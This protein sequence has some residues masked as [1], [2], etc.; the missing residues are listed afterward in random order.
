M[1]L[2]FDFLVA[3]LVMAAWV[4]VAFVLAFVAVFVLDLIGDRNY[5]RQNRK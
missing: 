3:A 2:L 1:S 4:G 5:G